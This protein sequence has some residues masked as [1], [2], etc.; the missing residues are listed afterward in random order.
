ML[1]ARH[2]SVS[3]SSSSNAASQSKDY[4]SLHLKTAAQAMEMGSRQVQG[5]G[6][7]CGLAGT[8]HAA[9]AH[10]ALAPH[11]TIWPVSRPAAG[12]ALVSSG[13]LLPGAV[14]NDTILCTVFLYVMYSRPFLALGR[15]LWF[16]RCSGGACTRGLHA[17]WRGLPRIYGCTSQ[18]HH[19]GLTAATQ[20][21][22]RREQMLNAL[23]Q[24]QHG[25][26]SG[27]HGPP[28]LHTR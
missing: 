4:L 24:Q 28:E 1:Q 12:P 16:P 14:R 21:A 8:H 23:T 19:I 15:L 11:P 5:F 22:C 3:S 2:T 9:A 18:H 27:L 20:Q 6:C 17:S 26:A 25:C 10:V 13:M 7:R